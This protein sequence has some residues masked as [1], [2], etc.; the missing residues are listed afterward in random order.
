MQRFPH[1]MCHDPFHHAHSFE[2][3]L[4]TGVEQIHQVGGWTAVSNP[5]APAPPAC[6]HRDDSS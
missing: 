4:A 5:R 3:Q 2:D 6:V 1:A